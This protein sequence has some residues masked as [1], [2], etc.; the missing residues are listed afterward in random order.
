VVAEVGSLCNFLGAFQGHVL[1][2]GQIGTLF[3]AVTGAA[4]HRHRSPLNCSAVLLR[5][6]AE[7]LIVGT[8]T[9]RGSSFAA[10]PTAR[11]I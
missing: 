11:L 6:G 3:D 10:A 2:G 7:H 9:G 1:T 5:D 8:S 4:L